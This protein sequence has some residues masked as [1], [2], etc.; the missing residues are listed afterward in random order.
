MTAVHFTPTSLLSGWL[1]TNIQ[2]NIT[3]TSH[4]I[5]HTCLYI[6][7]VSLFIF[8]L[9]S[10]FFFLHLFHFS[11]HAGCPPFPPSV[12]IKILQNRHDQ[13]FTQKNC[14]ATTLVYR[15]ESNPVVSSSPVKIIILFCVYLL[16]CKPCGNWKFLAVRR[17]SLMTYCECFVDCPFPVTWLGNV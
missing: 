11:G 15:Q 5:E 3:T 2:A 10:S 12:T 6:T 13:N 17:V 9:L 7:L 16:Y 4:N 8:F 14:Y 1:L